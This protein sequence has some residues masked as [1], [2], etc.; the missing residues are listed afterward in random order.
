MPMET[1][2]ILIDCST[3][4]KLTHSIKLQKI[5]LPLFQNCLH[6]IPLTVINM[7]LNAKCVEKSC[8]ILSYFYNVVI[9]T[10][11]NIEIFRHIWLLLITFQKFLTT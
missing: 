7:L 5:W 3:E 1:V 2:L 6:A 9:S 4:S 11:C 10:F 8:R